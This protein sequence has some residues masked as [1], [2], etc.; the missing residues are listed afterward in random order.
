MLRSLN[1]KLLLISLIVLVGLG[2]RAVFASGEIMNLDA[3][4]KELVTTTRQATTYGDVLTGLERAV[5][6]AITYAGTAR[7]A[8]LTNAQESLQGA[9]S[10]LETSTR[11][12]S[13]LGSAST[14]AT[15]RGYTQTARD[16][17]TRVRQE[18]ETLA[19]ARATGD[20][21]ALRQAVETLSGYEPQIAPLAD[22]LTTT[23][24]NRTT[25]DRQALQDG[26]LRLV[27][28]LVISLLALIGIIVVF[29]ILLNRGII[30]PL[31]Q[32]T[33]AATTGGYLDRVVDVTNNDEIGM[34]Q[35]AFNQMI[36]NQR[37]IR[38]QRDAALRATLKAKEAAEV[39]NRAKSTFLANM[40]HELRTP[41]NAILGYSELIQDEIGEMEQDAIIR[42]LD[43][44]HTSGEQ[45]LGLV[46]DL[47]DLSKIEAGKMEMAPEVFTVAALV[48]GVAAAIRPYIQ[49]NGNTLAVEVAPDIPLI[50]TDSAKVRQVLLNLLSNAAKFTH[51][52]RVTLDVRL[53]TEGARRWLLFHVI[54][55]GIGIPPELAAQLFQEF[56]Q[57]DPS[58]TRKY[59]GT[60]LGLA[61]SRRFTEMLGG[62]ITVESEVG[63]GSTFT[64]RLP[65]VVPPDSESLPPG[66]ATALASV[67][68]AAPASYKSGAAGAVLIID[69]DPTARELISRYLVPL[70]F[71]IAMASD[72]AEGLRLARQLH[73]VAI[74]LDVLLPTMDGW[75]VLSRLKADAELADIPVIMA[76]IVDNPQRGFA[77]GASDYLVKP[78]VAERLS[79][80][81]TKYRPAASAT[82]DLR[83]RQ[84]L[85]VEDDIPTRELLR[86]LLEKDGWA[87]VEAADGRAGLAQALAQ[88]PALILLDLMLPEL[89]GFGFLNAL[90]QTAEGREIPVILLTARELTPADHRRL[91]GYVEQILQK[92]AYTHE[93]LL[94][95]V[96]IWVIN[97]TQQK[98]AA[99]VERAAHGKNLDR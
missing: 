36:G 59:G 13:D 40:S 42:D 53:E 5:S 65:L 48:D 50:Y 4:S 58:T 75:T 15:D 57:G 28:S 1:Q 56:R 55:T 27:I 44:I 17:L 51:G 7:P 49:K 35:R 30:R 63:Q 62:A 97:Q 24:E 69:D 31:N 96:C 88:P 19:A 39:A 73:P 90:R 87:V 16:L 2:S 70:G 12:I 21:A 98:P 25:A 82:P 91:N 52:G 92:G 20:Q 3:A 76:T 86:R 22:Q 61:L 71:Q 80:T 68:S 72:G 10:A 34:L 38:E 6:S 89:D 18:V 79:A 99:A 32:L 9:Q 78:L 85:I 45:L 8:D 94:R 43:K 84:I 74:T 93:E 67:A 54:D 64:V 95:E 41:L 77:L 60:G 26:I 81:I 66:E 46:N 83:S 11:L 47:L 14:Q 33:A 37:T 29:M 23:F